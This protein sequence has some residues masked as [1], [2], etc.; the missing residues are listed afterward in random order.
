VRLVAHLAVRVLAVFAAV[1]RTVV[2]YCCVRWR[3]LLLTQKL[4]RFAVYGMLVF[5]VALP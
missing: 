3:R 5:A 2:C 1:V 4:A